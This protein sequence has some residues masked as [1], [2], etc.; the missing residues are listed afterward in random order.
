VTLHLHRIPWLHSAAL[1]TDGS[2]RSRRPARSPRVRPRARD[3][4]PARRVGRRGSRTRPTRR[5]QLRRLPR[6][7]D[8]RGA[9]ARANAALGPREVGTRHTLHRGAPP[10]RTAAVRLDDVAAWRRDRGHADRHGRNVLGRGGGPRSGRDSG[11]RSGCSRR[12][13]A[14]ARAERPIHERSSGSCSAPCPRRLRRD[15]D[16]G[17]SGRQAGPATSQSLARRRR[18]ADDRPPGRIAGRRLA[19]RRL[20]G[21]EHVRR[22]PVGAPWPPACCQRHAV[23]EHG[24][25]FVRV[26]RRPG[27]RLHRVVAPRSRPPDRLRARRGGRPP[28]SR[29][30]RR[31]AADV[32][33]GV[34]GRRSSPS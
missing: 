14:C 5:H 10:G 34:G 16:G 15:A 3:R 27:R 31:L 32:G 25:R 33:P 13:C 12:A 18:R 9:R 2:T 22:L 1:D 19:R 30:E 4:H 28:R 29:N 8:L 23:A 21:H 26:D 17:A 6:P 24:R 7:G 11:H 20:A